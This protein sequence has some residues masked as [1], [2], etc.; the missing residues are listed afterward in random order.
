MNTFSSHLIDEIWTPTP[1]V[2][3]YVNKIV[4]ESHDKDVVFLN[5][6][7]DGVDFCF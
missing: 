1:R 7:W 2:D 5:L 4:Q 6:L 3:F